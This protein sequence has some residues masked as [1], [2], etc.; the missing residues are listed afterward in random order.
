M[1]S[2]VFTLKYFYCFE[3]NVGNMAVTR[4]RPHRQRAN[5]CHFVSYIMLFQK[6]I[7]YKIPPVGGGGG[8]GGRGLWP[9]QGLFGK[10]ELILVLFVGLFDLRMFGFSW[11]LGRAAGKAA[12]RATVCD[13]GTPWTF[14]YLL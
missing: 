8:G 11:C 13:C 6:I 3:G 4:K 12:G 10:K 1:S 7:M 5:M 9:A 14:S 2:S